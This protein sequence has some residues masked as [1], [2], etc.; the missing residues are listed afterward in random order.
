MSWVCFS[1]SLSHSLLYTHSHTHTHTHT[2]TC[3]QTHTST[4]SPTCLSSQSAFALLCSDTCSHS[5]LIIPSIYSGCACGSL[6]D[7]YMSCIECGLLLVVDLRVHV[8]SRMELLL[9]SGFLGVLLLPPVSPVPRGPSR[10]K[11]LGPERLQF[12]FVI[13][14]PVLCLRTTDCLVLLL[15]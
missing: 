10:L 9:V 12:C 5:H 13:L 14:L 8:L 2:H 3:I 1:V 15:H 11:S 7:Y 4:L 6:S